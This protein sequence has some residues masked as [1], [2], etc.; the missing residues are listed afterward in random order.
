MNAKMKSFVSLL[1]VFVLLIPGF[2]FA[3]EN[4]ADWSSLLPENSREVSNKLALKLLDYASL[5][6]KDMASDTLTAEGFAILGQYNYEKEFTDP[7]HTVAYTLGAKK[8]TFKGAERTMLMITIRGTY[9]YEWQSN[10]DFAPSQ[11]NDTQYAE[12]FARAAMEAYFTLKP[13]IDAVKD[14]VIVVTG[15]SRGA[16]VANLL[17]VLLD[18]D[19]GEESIYCYTYA[20]PGTLRGEALKKQYTNIFNYLNPADIVT[21]L[22]LVEWGYGHAGTDIVLSADP[23]TLA[24]VD[25][26]MAVLANFAGSIHDYY[27]VRHSFTQ[28]GEGPIGIT[29]F[30]LMSA[31]VS[32]L[33]TMQMNG[34]FLSKEQM[35]MISPESDVYAVLVLMGTSLSG[36]K[37]VAVLMRHMP[38]TYKALIQLLDQ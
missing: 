30:E 5:Y 4:T 22:P 16:A 29:A 38:D 19:R 27:T 18:E 11:S 8:I 33:S 23:E 20:T 37:G 17:G 36:E 35:A 21:R 14:P 6:T 34:G 15:H 7:S 9:G 1:L 25:A 13:L 28:A 26:G 12:N 31:L 24:A 2:V 32:S 3:E 10:F